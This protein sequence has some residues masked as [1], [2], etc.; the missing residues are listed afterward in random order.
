MKT[1]SVFLIAL[2]LLTTAMISPFLPGSTDPVSGSV[3]MVVQVYSG[4]GL[5]S[6]VT[7]CLLLISGKS[8]VLFRVHVYATLFLFAIITLATFFAVSKLLGVGLLIATT[9]FA[10]FALREREFDHKTNWIVCTIF[11]PAALLI[12]QILVGPS[13]TR[14]SRNRAIENASELIHEIERY[15]VKTGTYPLTLNAV[16]KDYYP[17]V[18][19]VEK[20][21][22][23]Y[24]SNTYHVYF[25]Q[26]RF[27][28]DQFGTREIVAFNPEDE[29][30][31]VSHASWYMLLG[32]S[33]VRSTPGWYA[34]HDAR[35][36]H[37]KYFW[38]D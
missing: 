34:V 30:L 9:L 22:Y 17:D 27:F 1:L 21:H 13:L 35:L 14:Y 19:G 36:P 6:T 24:D 2:A 3:A 8:K 23:S 31:I 25:E 5:I 38:F 33:Q 37:W 12:I 18:A 29:H 32:Q 28:F 20:Y 7:G 4:L 10:R 11:L 15:K 26:P 16:W